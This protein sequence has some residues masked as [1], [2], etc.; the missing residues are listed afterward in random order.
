MTQGRNG[1]SLA[2]RAAPGFMTVARHLS[3]VAAVLSIAALVAGTAGTSYAKGKKPASDKDKFLEDTVVV[4]NFGSLFGGSIETFDVG[5]GFFSHPSREIVGPAT[6]LGAGNGAAGD[7]QSSLDGDIAV[8]VPF[9]VPGLC[10]AGCVGVWPASANGNTAPEDF[11]GGPAGT[12]GF[13]PFTGT[14]PVLNNKTGLFLDQG[15]AFN[16]PFRYV[17]VHASALTV[18]GDQ[19]A[20]ANFG[21]VVVGST[22]DFE[23]CGTPADEDTATTLGTITEYNSGDTG[24]VAPTPNF[25]VFELTLPPALAPIFSNATIGG[26]DTALVGPVGL[27]FDSL[28]HLWVVNEGI[29]GVP[30]FVVE[31]DKGAFGDASPIN[32]IGLFDATAPDFID[33]L[34]I[35]VSP[36]GDTIYVTDAG[37]NSIKIFDTTSFGGTRT[38]TIS[39]GKTKLVRPEGIALSGDDLYVVSNN[40]NS[41]LMFDDFTISGGNIRPSTIVK[42]VTSFRNTSHMNFPV[43][44][45]LPQFSAPPS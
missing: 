45:A 11:L 10:P 13:D 22:A 33:P 26:C 31:F 42:G 8:T 4:S 44:V 20:V 15:V 32:F 37:D 17:G 19:F 41:L 35:A 1:I 5:A 27:A 16:N 23:F 34:Y 30:G 18:T 21:Q 9:G 14:F 7:A 12:T 2:H 28:G 40:A 29:T 39:G 43:G 3:V 24:N 36:D 38:G 6:L 25:P